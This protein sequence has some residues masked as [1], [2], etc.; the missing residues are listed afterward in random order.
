MRVRCFYRLNRGNYLQNRWLAPA[1]LGYHTEIFYKSPA[2]LMYLH[3][4]LGIYAC[5]TRDTPATMR[6]YKKRLDLFEKNLDL[7]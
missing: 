4:Y 1:Y 5:D 3:E 2:Y 6:V 7:F